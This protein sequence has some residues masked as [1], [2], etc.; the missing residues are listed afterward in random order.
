MLLVAHWSLHP[1]LWGPI[2]AELERDHRVVRYDDRGT[3][4]SERVGPY[5]IESGADDLEA[6]AEAAGGTPCVAIGLMDGGNKAVR[7]AA[8]RPDLIS[9]VISP[10]GAPLGRHALSDSDAMIASNTVVGAFMQQL[11]T[12]YRGALRAVVEAANPEMPQDDVR[13]R[14]NGQ[15]EHVPME[16][17]AAR[18][19]AW[20]EDEGAE[21]PGRELGDRLVILLSDAIT[22]GWLPEPDVMKPL[23]PE[24]FPDAVVETVED[25]IIS[26]PDLTAEIVRER[27]ARHAP[28]PASEWTASPGSDPGERMAAIGAAAMPVSLLFPWYGFKLGSPLSATAL[29]SFNFAHAA[30]LLTAA[31]VIFLLVTNDGRRAA[32]AAQRAAGC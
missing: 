15:V 32:A 27:G 9:H 30:L 2:T 10:G 24:H 23:L 19:R 29:D 25:G 21:E 20:A 13:A 6:V 17:A 3:G 4:Q 22:G 26:R 18:V 16:V 31:A 7:V 11:E 28:A 1:M 8:R 5:D 12:D 14:V